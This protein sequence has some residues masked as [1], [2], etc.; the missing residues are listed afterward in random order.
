MLISKVMHPSV[1]RPAGDRA[2]GETS[3]VI[4]KRFYDRT[5][6]TE[7]VGERWKSRKSK[8]D[9]QW[10][11]RARSLFCNEMP[12]PGTREHAWHPLGGTPS[13]GLIPTA[14]AKGGVQIPFSTRANG[15]QGAHLNW[16]SCREGEDKSPTSKTPRLLEN[17]WCRAVTGN[18]SSAPT[19]SRFRMR[20]GKS[21][22]VFNGLCTFP[23]KNKS[24]VP[25]DRV[26]RGYCRA[27]VRPWRSFSL[28]RLSKALPLLHRGKR[29]PIFGST[30]LSALQFSLKS[31]FC[32]SCI[33]SSLWFLLLWPHFFG[34]LYIH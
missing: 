1:T 31:S 33:L 8:G 4:P 30:K 14:K 24:F 27:L 17:H 18:S 6:K 16:W 34:A 32:L 19:L 29:I 15:I 12:L 11:E 5:T 25:A 2:M 3:R 7:W 22:F 9:I 26:K 28:L 23:T 21:K 10:P 13:G 20:A